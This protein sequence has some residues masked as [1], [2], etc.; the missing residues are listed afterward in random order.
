MVN[1]SAIDAGHGIVAWSGTIGAQETSHSVGAEFFLEEFERVAFK[2]LVLR[3]FQRDH[4]SSS[5][6]WFKGA[7]RVSYCPNANPRADSNSLA[8]DSFE[9]DSV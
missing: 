9:H 1:P 8:T 2:L 4:G 6:A 3:L 5:S 7:Q